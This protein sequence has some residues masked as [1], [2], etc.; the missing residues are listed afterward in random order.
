MDT[1]A[2]IVSTS[3]Y[4]HNY[5]HAANAL[6]MYDAVRTFGVPDSHI[7]L[8]LAGSIPCDE[9]NAAAGSIY[10]TTERELDLYPHDTQVDYRGEEVS[11][12]SVLS[13]LADRLPAGTP[14]SRR[15]QSGRRSRLLVY[16]T[17]HG[18]DG[19]LKFGDQYELTSDEIASAVRH[20]YALGR[21]AEVLILLDTYA[22]AHNHVHTHAHAYAHAHAACMGFD[23]SLSRTHALAG[24]C[25]RSSSSVW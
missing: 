3:R 14:A 1:H 8:M 7:V 22:A 17:G 19:F 20:A 12:E 21:C 15:L 13:V 2:I 9:R 16:L 4:F 23:S 6:A 11:V 24:P 25:P 10:H 5:R 18:G